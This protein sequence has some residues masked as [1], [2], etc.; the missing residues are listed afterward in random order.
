MKYEEL[1]G[2]ATLDRW[3]FAIKSETFNRSIFLNDVVVDTKF[4]LQ[5]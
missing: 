4:W 3:A 2:R 1:M 5:F